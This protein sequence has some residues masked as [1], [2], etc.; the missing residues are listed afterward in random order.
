MTSLTNPGSSHTA[1][2]IGALDFVLS[3]TAALASHM[4]ECAKTRSQFFG[5]YAVLEL[6][7][8]LLTPRMVTT[9]VIAVVLL[10]TT[11]AV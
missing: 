1:R 7:Q 6:V 8:A 11:G 4:S 5:V 2:K 10:V 9:A 3:D